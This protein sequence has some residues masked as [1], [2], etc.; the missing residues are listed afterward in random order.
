[1][2]PNLIT[3]PVAFGNQEYPRLAENSDRAFVLRL[4]TS[5][6]E[7]ILFGRKWLYVGV[8][9]AWRKGSKVLFVRKADSF[10]GSGIIGTVK[11]IEELEAAE[12]ELCFK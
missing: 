7:R 5:E 12:R 2:S 1:M 9:R 4:N 10:L 3:V 11:T 6:V 8:S